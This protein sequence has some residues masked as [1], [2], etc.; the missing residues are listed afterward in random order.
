MININKGFPLFFVIMKIYI[1]RHSKTVWNE[2]KR[3]QGRC[4]SPLSQ[5]GIDNAIALKTYLNESHLHFDYIYSSPIPR[6]YNTAKI[7]FDIDNIIKDDRLMEMN[8]GVF[9]GR[10]ISH[11]LETD[12]ELY[13]N[14]WHHP[15]LF[16]CIPEGETYDDVIDRAMSFLSDLKQLNDK[17]TVF[18]VTH[19]MFFIVL[20][21]C[22]L[23]L[24]KQDYVQINQKVVEGCS[25]TIFDVQ[26]DYHLITYNQHDY[27]PHVMNASF[28]K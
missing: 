21:A 8:F 10:K 7:L 26:E 22:M 15:D 27:L 24:E 13:H 11:V 18:I 6:A 25:L 3:L 12:Y 23:H 16:T 1:T 2:E 20:L 17:S 14:L 28:A 19:G 5:D 4:D 9:E